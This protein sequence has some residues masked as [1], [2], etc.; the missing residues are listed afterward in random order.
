MPRHLLTPETRKA[1]AL[2]AA[3]L[4]RKQTQYICKS[5]SDNILKETGI[6]RERG[7]EEYVVLQLKSVS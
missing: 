3:L 4:H 1:S 2:E 6:L 5:Y 7:G